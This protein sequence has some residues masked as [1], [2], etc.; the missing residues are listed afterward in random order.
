MYQQVNSASAR[1]TAPAGIYVLF[2][3][4]TKPEWLTVLRGLA[5][6]GVRWFQL[7]TKR[8]TSLL[9]Q[10]LLRQARGALPAGTVLICN[11]DITAAASC[12]GV[13][14]GPDD[15]EPASARERLGTSAW[16]GA[17]C[18][19]PTRA[20]APEFA[21]VDY[22]GVGTWRRTA[23]KPDAGTPITPDILRAFVSAAQRPVFAIGG[24]RIDDLPTI[25]ATGAAGVAIASAV[26]DAPDPVAAARRFVERWQEVAA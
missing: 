4:A 11:D 16:I 8:A 10:D 12:D 7:R 23:T 3:P 22:F 5:D 17:S 14:L 13:H 6:V 21:A 2:D 26:W 19:D 15:A 9:R 20:N 18:D 1:D 25:A 24:I